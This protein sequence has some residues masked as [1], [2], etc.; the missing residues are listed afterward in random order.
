MAVIASLKQEGF[1]A[2]C[3]ALGTFRVG[4][5]VPPSPLISPLLKSCETLHPTNKT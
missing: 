5:A 4:L 1:H 3:S 2:H